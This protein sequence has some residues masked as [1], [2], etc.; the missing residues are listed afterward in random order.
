MFPLIKNKGAAKQ[1]EVTKI[2]TSTKAASSKKQDDMNDRL[3]GDF[4][5][6]TEM[7]A[8]KNEEKLAAVL[9]PEEKR[10][11]KAK[12]KSNKIITQKHNYGYYCLLYRNLL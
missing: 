2:P 12:K 11:K 1:L 4:R 3:M 6:T 10:K 5:L 7:K 8:D 9:P